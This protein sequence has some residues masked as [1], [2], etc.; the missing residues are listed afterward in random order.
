MFLKAL[1]KVDTI[2]DTLV[3]VR[4]GVRTAAEWVNRSD[5]N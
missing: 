1:G 4:N 3:M 2:V 5:L